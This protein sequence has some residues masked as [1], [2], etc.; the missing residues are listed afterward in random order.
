[1]DDLS[2][3]LKRAPE[4]QEL[5]GFL[6]K[7]SDTVVSDWAY[8]AGTSNQAKMSSTTILMCRL[9]EA[10]ETTQLQPF[11]H[12]IIGM[13]IKEHLRVVYR[14]LFIAKPRLT[15]PA[16]DLLRIICLFPAGS[17]ASDLY[18]SFD[19]SLKVIPKLLADQ[20]LRKPFIKFYLA[21]VE[22][23]PSA[24][25]KDLVSQRKIVS[26]WFSKIDAD[27]EEIV[28]DT[29][30]VFKDFVIKDRTF[31]KSAKLGLFN[32]WVLKHFIKLLNRADVGASMADF[33][34]Y[35]LTDTEYGVH[36]SDR[37]CY[38]EPNNKL[39]L[40]LLRMLKP[41]ESQHQMDLAVNTMKSYTE[42]VHPYFTGLQATF[43]FAPKVSMFWFSF[44]VLHSRV[45]SLSIPEFDSVHSP[46]D[47][48]VV[49]HILPPT[50]TRATLTSG[51]TYGD[52]NLVRLQTAQIVLFALKK[53]RAVLDIYEQRVWDSSKVLNEV[54]ERLPEVHLFLKPASPQLL[55]TTSLACLREYCAIAPPASVLPSALTSVLDREHVSGLELVNAYDILE[56]QTV[57]TGQAKW[58]NRGNDKMSFFTKLVKF[59]CYNPDL[60]SQ[61]AKL[62]QSLVEK[63]LAFQNTTFVR[64]VDALLYSLEVVL[65]TIK[66]PEQEKLW[67][68]IDES[69]SRSVTTPYPYVDRFA[70]NISPFAVA[71]VDQWKHVDKSTPSEHILNWIASFVRDLGIIG[72]D[73]AAVGSLLEDLGKVEI[74][75]PMDD[76]FEFVISGPEK[77]VL[78]RDDIIFKISTPLEFIATV[79]RAGST[80]SLASFLLSNLPATLIHYLTE[81]ICSQLLLNESTHKVYLATLKENEL[82]SPALAK[83]L[84]SSPFWLEALDFLSNEYL[85][86][87]FAETKNKELVAVLTERRVPLPLD[88]ALDNLG[89]SENLRL[90]KIDKEL[91]GKLFDQLLKEQNFDSICAVIE[92]SN[93]YDPKLPSNPMVLLA[94]SQFAPSYIAEESISSFIKTALER[95]E[96]QPDVILKL[97]NMWKAKLDSDQLSVL[98]EYIG[99]VK[100]SL[101]P[102]IARVADVLDGA[103]SQVWLKR[104]VL[105]LTKVL[106]MSKSS[107]SI[108]E[109]VEEFSVYLS[110]RKSSIWKA[111]NSNSLNALITTILGSEFTVDLVSLASQLAFSVVSASS[112]DHTEHLQT[113]LE[114]PVPKDNEKY[115][116]TSILLWRLFMV[117]PVMNSTSQIQDGILCFYNGSWASSS[118][119]VFQVL[120]TI[121]SNQN[122]SWVDK[123]TV[124]ELRGE[125]LVDDYE[126]PPLI[127]NAGNTLQV[128][129]EKA[130]IL[131]TCQN[132]DTEAKLKTV[133]PGSSFDEVKELLE[134][135]DIEHPSFGYHDEFLI[136]TLASCDYI[137]KED[138]VDVRVMAESNA[139]AF[140][141]SCLAS[142]NQNVVYVAMQLL[143][144]IS[145]SLMGEEK[146]YREQ[147][148]TQLIV[149]K[150]L[151]FVKT[152]GSL[153]GHLAILIAEILTV[154]TKPGHFLHEMASDWLLLG[155][156]IKD[157][158]LPLF[159]NIQASTSEHKAREM[160]WLVQAYKHA[161]LDRSV[162]NIYIKNGVIEWLLTQMA[163]LTPKSFQLKRAIEQLL[164]KVEEIGGS[165]NLIG[166]HAALVMP[167]PDAKLVTSVPKDKIFNWLGL[168]N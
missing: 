20:E 11:G 72:E 103:G 49:S 142:K 111:V 98:D 36:F 95:L 35:M 13:I 114:R 120:E 32:D 74:K 115:G 43:S 97:M 80:P 134:K 122:S 168:S 27:S 57:L 25:R 162:V 67:A 71:L 132:Y 136:N 28:L 53:L 90:Q 89:L 70:T 59:A 100:H 118:Q 163:Q 83:V 149:N 124:W 47:D 123:V 160:Q 21:F 81:P 76:Y 153:P 56:V 73:V 78:A 109:F 62:L 96:E 151:M 60:G 85:I 4:D 55:Q 154:V 135:H 79:H 147:V 2:D 30:R 91:A 41:W 8:A 18:N 116:A 125:E 14:S 52:S 138:K 42:L 51:L 128:T 158:D 161:L 39:A 145:S 144:A 104:S 148:S 7:K 130:R 101:N 92:A 86:K 44:A 75:L 37:G 165:M 22:R 15:A 50:L 146:I 99:T 126:I 48:A 105:Q 139:L 46:L 77:T 133:S 58:W 112:I 152:K 84:E 129:L 54:M 69:I 121:E 63:T 82:S 16:L 108:R 93:F 113:L 65:P 119:L 166:R 156:S 3:I 1:M 64:P 167:N 131:A 33:L 106:A 127:T 23:S 5:A 6:Q 107:A 141:I 9:L 38:G 10:C 155:P 61:C 157:Y 137:I 159:K 26:G 140:V 17:T 29:L 24:V 94:A 31:T 143:T 40:S 110:K 12:K 19:F 164:S 34:Y 150:V 66:G 45:I 117:D 102:D 87:K 68:L 88:L